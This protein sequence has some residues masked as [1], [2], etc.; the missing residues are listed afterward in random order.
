MTLSCAFCGKSQLEVVAI[1]AGPTCNICDECVEAC[2][3]AL[4]NVARRRPAAAE[5]EYQS[6]FE[7]S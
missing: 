1:V 3:A 2:V 4:S 5:I 7:R 6:W